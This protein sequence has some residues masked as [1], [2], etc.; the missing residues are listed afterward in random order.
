MI[1]VRTG[2]TPIST[3]SQAHSARW[4]LGGAK[5]VDLAHRLA[6]AARFISSISGAGD[7]RLAVA[8]AEHLGRWPRRWIDGSRDHG[9]AEAATVTHFTASMASLRAGSSRPIRPMSTQVPRQV[10]RT[11]AA[12]LQ[13]RVFQQASASTRSP[14]AA[15]WSDT[16]ME[17]LAVER[18]RL[19][20]HGLLAVAVVHE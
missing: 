1:M 16:F 13:A 5:N 9:D 14:W 15:S 11:E 20:G 18:R 10:R 17:V 6:R 3:Q 4:D 8:D 12:R 7:R 2:D 19:P